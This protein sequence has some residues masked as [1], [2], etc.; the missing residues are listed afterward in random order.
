[1]KFGISWMPDCGPEVRS[2]TAYFDDVMRLSVLAEELGF[3]YIKMTEHYLHAAGG[4]CPSPL[5]LLAAVG[6]KTQRIRLMTGGIQ[7]SFHHPIQL[8]AQT[9]QVDA[10]THG[11]LDVG[12]ARAFLPYE[13]EAFGVDMHKS[14]DRF[15][16][17]VDTVVR[18]WTEKGVTADT[19]YFS[20]KD[21]T[22]FPEPFQQPHPPV[23]ICA[24][25]SESSFRWAGEQGFN[26]LMTASP[27][28]EVIDIAAKHVNMY[29]EVF[30]K[31]HGSSGRQ[32]EVALS[33]PLM[34]GETDAE[35]LELA[36]PKLQRYLEVW[37]DAAKSLAEVSSPDYAGYQGVVKGFDAE[38][39]QVAKQTVLGGPETIAARV[40]DLRDGLGVDTILWI[41]DGGSPDYADMERTVRLFTDKVL[42]KLSD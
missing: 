12:L 34:A 18:L 25:M 24:L 20:F 26:L 41:V 22:S 2:A 13:F 5:A 28:P 17:T 3:D 32:P 42:P 35:A 7:A 39:D 37:G 33:L 8:A 30:D 14:R 19:P 23:W 38:I 31:H 4:Y 27:R 9:A 10:M 36:R 11:R 1:M 29:R 40:E 15:R 6:A 21:A 16:A